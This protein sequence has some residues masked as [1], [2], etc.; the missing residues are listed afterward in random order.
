MEETL[1]PN[2]TFDDIG[3]KDKMDVR[4][5]RIIGVSD[6]LRNPKK[7]PSEENTV[8]A[9]HLVVDTGIEHRDV[10][11]NIVDKYTKEDLLNKEV[12]FI[13][14]LEPTQI[15][16]VVSKG[17]IFLDGEEKLITGKIGEVV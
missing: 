7:E 10:V 6:I 3:N 8:K 17:M 13:L 16:G 15:R 9:Y 5:C 14:N 2:I 11:T 12:A 4:I 1:K